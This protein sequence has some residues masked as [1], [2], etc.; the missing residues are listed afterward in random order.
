MKL[1]YQEPVGCWDDGF[2]IGNGILGAMVLAGRGTE[3]I[4]LNH[5]AFWTHSSS[6]LISKAVSNSANPDSMCPAL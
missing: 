5:T 1:W 2:P 6:G 4:G 3:E